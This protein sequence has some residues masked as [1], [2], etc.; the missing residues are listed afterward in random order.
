MLYMLQLLGDFVPRPVY[1]GFASGPTEYFH[2]HAPYM[3]L[4]QLAKPACPC[5]STYTSTTSLLELPRLQLATDTVYEG[6]L[7]QCTFKRKY[8]YG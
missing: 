6:V 4:L 1:R 5:V 8:C 2:P 3:G 7:V